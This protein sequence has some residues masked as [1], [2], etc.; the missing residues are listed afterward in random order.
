MDRVFKIEHVVYIF[1]YNAYIML[2][3]HKKVDKL[4]RTNHII[5]L[6]ME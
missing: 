1:I 2:K 4:K 3:L 5:N 6:N